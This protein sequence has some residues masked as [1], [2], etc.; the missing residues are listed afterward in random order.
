[1]LSIPLDRR[2][3]VHDL[4][5]GVAIVAIALIIGCAGV[6]RSGPLWVDGPQY[7]NAAAMI[8]DWIRSGQLLHPFAFARANY[9]QYPAFSVPYHPP[10]YPGLLGAFF[11]MTGVSYSSARVF[12]ALL[13][14]LAGCSF[15]VILRRFAVDR[16][17]A[18]V[19]TLLLLTMPEI[20]TWSRDTMS[21]IPALA[22]VLVGSF[23]FLRWLETVRYRDAA[24]AFGFA[25]L[26]FFSKINVIGVLLAW[27][28]WIAL[29]GSWRKM[30]SPSLLVPAVLFVA[31]VTGWSIF[32]IPFARYETQSSMTP[33]HGAAPLPDANLLVY[34]YGL[35]AMTGWSLLV[36]SV[37][38]LVVALHLPEWRRLAAMWLAWFGAYLVFLLMLPLHYEARYL[39]FALPA[40]AALAAMLFFARSRS[41]VPEWIA[42]ALVGVALVENVVRLR[43]QSSG[44]I[45]YKQM[46]DRL[47]A[48]NEPGN[49]LIGV[50]FQNDLDFSLPIREP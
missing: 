33:A 22:F 27:P 2:R 39:T 24:F 12:I 31:V 5:A 13:L 42:Y 45:G 7:A 10:G 43:H 18:F 28:F 40:L 17:P 32:F 25:A 6:T 26:A 8:R 49:V 37:L 35:P 36:V 47:A 15:Y 14:G 23:G 3:D 16:G 50:P 46:A 34:L 29:R 44:V 41:R 20:V 38:G 1:M 4:G 11:L 9:A 48:L 19:C 30:F 21:E